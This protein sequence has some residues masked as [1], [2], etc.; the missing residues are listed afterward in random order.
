MGDIKKW[1]VKHNHNDGRAGTVEVTTEIQKS[2][3]FQYGNGKAGVITVG[4]FTQGY[5]LRY[6]TAKDLHMIM[7]NEY[8]GTGL[9]SATER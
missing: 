7:L 4:S 5:D 8:F 2:G 1:L 3:G 6:N 9:V